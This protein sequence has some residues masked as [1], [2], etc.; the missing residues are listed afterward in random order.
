[1]KYCRIILLTALA[2]APYLAHAQSVSETAPEARDWSFRFSPYL[3]GS[4]TEGR[5]AHERLPFTLQGSKSFS[6][7]LDD[8]ELGGMGMFEAQKG[9]YGLLL[10]GQYSRSATVLNAPLGGFALPVQLK[11][12]HYSTL[13]AARYGLYEDA[14]NTLDLVAGL[15]IW[16]VRMRMA[17]SAPLPTPPPIPQSYGG[18]QNHG[19]V[20]AQIGVKARHT[21][22]SQFFA[23]GWVLAGAG[24]SKLSTDV[25]LVVGY[26]AS[27]HLSVTTGY[28]WLSTNYTT[29]KG[30]VFDARMHGPG[31]GLE[32]VF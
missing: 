14:S 16:Q 4:A 18:E 22:P 28:R 10:D 23:G 27:E 9:R 2:A 19:W 26:R 6:D 17:Y 24:E 15:R 7:T 20:D 12:R 32:Y 11:T 1:M 30:F 3:W 31:V 13:V 29:G 21:F 25:M 5:F 8:L